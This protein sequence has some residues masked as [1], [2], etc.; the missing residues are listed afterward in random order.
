MPVQQSHGE[1]QWLNYDNGSGKKGRDEI[2]LDYG[3]DS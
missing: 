1:W 3:M 2:Y